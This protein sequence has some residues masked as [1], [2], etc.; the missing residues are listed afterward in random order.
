MTTKTKPQ[1]PLPPGDY[2][3]E[4]PAGQVPRMRHWDGEAW[5]LGW[6]VNDTPEDIAWSRS[7]VGVPDEPAWITEALS[8]PR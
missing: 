7:K 4:V 1:Q 6:W 8:A 3:V 2:P 5:S